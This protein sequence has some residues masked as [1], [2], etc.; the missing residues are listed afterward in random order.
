[1]TTCPID[2]RRDNVQDEWF[3]LEDDEALMERLDE[4]LHEIN[5]PQGNN[6]DTPSD[7]STPEF[8]IYDCPENM[9][10]RELFEDISDGE[11]YQYN[12]TTTWEEVDQLLL[13]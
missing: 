7:R 3:D 10:S 4:T 5:E 12:Q 8:P 1:M 11:E 9:Y 6:G 2:M 13:F